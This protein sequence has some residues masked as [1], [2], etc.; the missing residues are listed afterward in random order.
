MSDFLTR[1]SEAALG[2]SRAVVKPLVASRYAP[3][4]GEPVLEME[5][6]VDQSTAVGFESTAQSNELAPSAVR[7]A[8][9]EPA[10]AREQKSEIETRAVDRVGLSETRGM[11]TLKPLQVSSRQ[12]ELS[13]KVQ[14]VEHITEQDVPVSTSSDDRTPVSVS[15]RPAVAV[16]ESA[17][18]PEGQPTSLLVAPL[19]VRSISIEVGET[20]TAATDTHAPEESETGKRPSVPSFAPVERPN[21]NDGRREVVVEGKLDETVNEAVR[22]GDDAPRSSNRVNEPAMV[23]SRSTEVISTDP[24]RHLD[25]SSSSLRDEWNAP[26]NA[27]RRPVTARAI[28]ET[29]VISDRGSHDGPPVIRVTIGRIDVRAV[30][31]PSPP[32]QTAA[33]TQ[34]KLSLEEYLRQHNGRRA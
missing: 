30:A 23:P 7:A 24:E 25:H 18:E 16:N 33:P 32:V 11:E 26:D 27:A 21:L 2:V 8:L 1:A 34:P 31:P 12:D 28:S 13:P 29:A 17:S 22:A 4:R 14:T 19:S 9:N 10:N 20:Q 3:G 5:T 15:V 6:V